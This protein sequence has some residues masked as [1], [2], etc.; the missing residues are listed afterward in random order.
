MTV[1]M[2]PRWLEVLEHLVEPARAVREL[3]RVARRFVVAS[4]PS[5]EDDN[6]EHIQLFDGAALERMFTDAGARSVTVTYVRGHIV[7]VA[8]L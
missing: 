4:V 5:K 8:T 2:S 7:C 6:P 1:S 3:V